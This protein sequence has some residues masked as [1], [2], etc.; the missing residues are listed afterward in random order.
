[1]TRVT[2]TVHL[3]DR[4]IDLDDDPDLALED[5]PPPPP[6]TPPHAEVFFAFGQWKVERSNLDGLLGLPLDH[7][8]RQRVKART[9]EALATLI[10]ALTET[11]AKDH[12]VR[13]PRR[14]R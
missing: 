6:A 14:R 1:M 10:A 9:D 7:P 5:A 2:T 11:T 4:R 12:Q 3:D 8:G 13:T